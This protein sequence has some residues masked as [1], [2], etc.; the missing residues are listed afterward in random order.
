MPQ[1]HRTT[2]SKRSL[3]LLPA[4]FIGVVILSSACSRHKGWRKIG[5]GTT[6]EI[7]VDMLTAEAS[8]NS[9]ATPDSLRASSYQALLARY[10][11]TMADWDS[12]IAWYGRNNLANY[13]KIY[14]YAQE[15][16]TK[17]QTELQ[18]RVRYLDSIDLRTSKLR[19]GDIDEVNLL[20]D[21]I[22]VYSPG[23]FGYRSFS[24]SPL[25]PYNAGSEVGFIV[26]LRG[27]KGSATSGSLRM[28]LRLLYAD[29]SAT[30]ISLKQLRGGL[31]ELRYSIPMGKQ[32]L[33][34]EGS[35]LGIAPRSDNPLLVVDSFS[36]VRH[37]G[38]SSSAASAPNSGLIDEPQVAVADT[39]PQ[40]I[41]TSHDNE[42]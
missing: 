31:N 41:D 38:S 19:S 42:F 32:M 10:G 14:E 39:L 6:Q 37:F 35:L 7:L 23:K 29:S 17:R 36:F 16:L 34:A 4:L 30:T 24:Y 21:S 15:V 13:R 25:T 27:L 3:R 20:R 18:S 1:K 8:F 26:R 40:T 12:T 11:Y 22:S 28:Q 2:R 9:K 33:R 5:M